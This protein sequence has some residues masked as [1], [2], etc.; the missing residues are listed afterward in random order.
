MEK[1][2]PPIEEVI[3][4]LGGLTK[5]AAAL[6]IDNPSVISNWRTRGRI[7][8]DWVL[9]VSDATGIAPNVLRP[10]L[11]AIFASK[12]VPSISGVPA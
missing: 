11:A 1:P 12:N 9:P 4:R 8:V 10:D 2:R 6:G 5:T 7:P 3:E